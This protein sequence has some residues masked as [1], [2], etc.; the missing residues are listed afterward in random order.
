MM[1]GDSLAQALATIS[2][3]SGVQV[4]MDGQALIVAGSRVDLPATLTGERAE[5]FGIA[6]L[7]PTVPRG[8]DR[9]KLLW[10]VLAEARAG[11]PAVLLPD[12]QLENEL[13]ERLNL[14]GEASLA[15]A[16]ALKE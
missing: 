15:A 5:L 3:R 13:A 7:L 6:G 16:Q 8:D 12:R 10:R 4:R 2:A 1:P 11:D 9:D 14:G